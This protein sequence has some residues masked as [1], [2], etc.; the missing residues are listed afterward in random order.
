MSNT[1]NRWKSQGGINRRAMNNILSNHKQ[2]TNTLTIPQQIGI[3]NTT[4]E[5]YGDKRDMEN[6]SLYKMIEGEQNYDNIITYYPFNNLDNNVDTDVNTN[7][8]IQLPD[9]IIIKN[10]SLNT[11]LVQKNNFNLSLNNVNDVS[12]DN[13]QKAPYFVYVP[14]FSQNAIQFRNNSKILISENP[15]NTINA[16]G[17]TENTQQISTILTF[18]TFV[19]IPDGTENFCIFALD[20]IKQHGMFLPS[21]DGSYSTDCFYLWYKGGSYSNQTQIYYRHDNV[22]NNNNNNNNNTS[23]DISNNECGELATDKWHKLMVVFGGSYIAIYI[24]GIQTYMRL[25]TGGSYIPNKPIAFN[26]GSIYSPVNYHYVD[27]NYGG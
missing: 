7:T 21:N 10:Q 2:T 23:V 19:Y 11:N 14:T 24:D 27:I 5:Q 17:Q 26:L 9:D 13:G 20:D 12:E 6:S 3:S 1:S 25:V 16:I 15:L 4:I 18:E 8:N 22:D